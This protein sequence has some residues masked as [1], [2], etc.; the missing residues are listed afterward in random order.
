MFKVP[1]Q[2]YT[3]EF[4]LAAVQRVNDGQDSAME[5]AISSMTLSKQIV[6]K[7]YIM[8]IFPGIGV[9]PVTLRAWL[10]PSL[11][12]LR[13]SAKFLTTMFSSSDKLLLDMRATSETP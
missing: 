11:W 1:K 12:L 10:W 7:Q 13:P 3:A 5:A 6:S 2:V 9:C 8:E 4:K